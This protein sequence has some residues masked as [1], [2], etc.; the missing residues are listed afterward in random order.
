M[1]FWSLRVENF[2]VR[3]REI[4]ALLTAGLVNFNTLPLL[5]AIIIRAIIS[6]YVIF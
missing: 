3:L 2:Y 4:A 1:I 5:I 6:T